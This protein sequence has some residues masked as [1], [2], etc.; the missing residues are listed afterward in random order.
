MREEDKI[1]LD[2]S[3]APFDRR[4]G[5]HREPPRYLAARVALG[6]KPPLCCA[7]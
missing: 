1:E 7:S 4:H 2:T 5:R 6:A 3:F